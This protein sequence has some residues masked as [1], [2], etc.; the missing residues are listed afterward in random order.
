MT[1][2]LTPL[3][4]RVRLRLAVTRRIDITCGW[5]IEHR[6][7]GP[8]ILIWRVCGLWPGSRKATR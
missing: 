3:P 1:V 7:H 6:L 2:L 8:A 4:R 5:L